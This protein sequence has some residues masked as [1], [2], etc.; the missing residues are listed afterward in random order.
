MEKFTSKGFKILMVAVVVLIGAV[1]YGLSA[2]SSVFSN[3]FGIVSAPLLTAGTNMT[4]GAKEFIDLDGMSK[5]DLKKLYV[6]LSEEN[7]KL[8]EQLVDYYEVKEEN[9]SYEN[10]LSVKAAM[11]DLQLTAASVVGRDPNDVFFDFTINRGYLSGISEGDA[12]ITEMGVVGV[13]DE[14]YATSSRV[15]SIL[16]EKTQIGA[17][18][19]ECGESGVIASDIQFANS[20]KVKLL[21]L[22]R[23]TQVQ[24]GTI[25][26]TSGAG[27]VFPS[28]LLIGRVDSVERSNTDASFYAIVTPYVDI[29]TVS[30]VFVI[31]DFEGKGDVQTNLPEA[32]LEAEDPAATAQK[33]NE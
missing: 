14:V 1:I 4:E 7:R 13:I 10:I 32:S 17:S 2:G 25:I 16:S 5:E 21:Y 22:T 11:P 30:D 23:D 24:A 26:T 6:E 28:D 31:T 29:K 12:V 27:G 18:A 20:G 19:K 8:R 9:A 33:G 3:L 15:R